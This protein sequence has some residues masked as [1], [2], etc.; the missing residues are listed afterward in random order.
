MV[1]KTSGWF[2]AVLISFAMAGNGNGHLVGYSPAGA[3]VNPGNADLSG[4]GSITLGTA[5]KAPLR[6]TANGRPVQG[7][8]S[9]AYTVTTSNIPASAGIHLGIIGLSN[10]N[11]PLAG[12][13]MTDCTL[14]A[15][16]DVVGADIAPVLT[17]PSFTWTPVVLPAL[18]PQLSGFS[19]YLQSV[20]LGTSENT[21]FGFGAISSNGL[22]CTIGLQ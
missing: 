8:A 14:L 11:L 16:L 5:D 12:F 10:P 19:F 9:V 17:T 6:L 20:I 1:A 3:S 7:A 4:L 18:P 2:S 13:G 21:A 22:K 15:N